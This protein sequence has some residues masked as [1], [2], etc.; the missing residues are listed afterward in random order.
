MNASDADRGPRRPARRELLVLGLVEPGDQDVA[1]AVE[2]R[3]ERQE[4]PVGAGA[5]R[6]MARCAATE[7]EHDAEERDDV[8]GDD[9]VRPSAGERVRAAGDDDAEDDEAEL[10]V[11]SHLADQRPATGWTPVIERTRRNR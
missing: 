8:R 10:G 1:D 4:H 5:S 6:R 7:A 3:G 11:P 2:Q 9:E